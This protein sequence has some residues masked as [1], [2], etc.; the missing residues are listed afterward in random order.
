MQNRYP[1]FDTRNYGC[2]RMTD[3]L[4]LLNIP[5]ASFNDPNNPVQNAALL[6][7]KTK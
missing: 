6:F 7:I 4:K 2:R 1:D 3:L 5:T